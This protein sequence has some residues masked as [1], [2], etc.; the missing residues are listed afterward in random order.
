MKLPEIES[1][2][3]EVDVNSLTERLTELGA[4]YQFTKTFV[5]IWLAGHG[6]KFRVRKEG[7][8][9]VVEHKEMMEIGAKMKACYETGF[10]TEDMDDTL[11]FFKKIGFSEI[12]KS[13]K[14]RTAYTLDLG[15][16]EG[17]VEIV[18]DTYSDLNGQAI[19]TFIEIETKRIPDVIPRRSSM[20]KEAQN[21]IFKVTALLGYQPSDLKDWSSVELSAYYKRD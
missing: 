2:I 4:V 18:F 11:A 16:L 7:D 15:L 9:V 13:V 1:K 12:S 14:E 6:T 21:V 8:T 17:A 20:V 10:Q 3:L 5:A 19:P